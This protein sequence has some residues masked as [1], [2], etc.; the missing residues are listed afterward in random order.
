MEVAPGSLVIMTGAE[1]S[2]ACVTFEAYRKAPPL[3]T[4]GWEQVVEVGYRSPAGSLAFSDGDDID[5]R[6][7]GGFTLAGKGSYR[8]RIHVRGRDR[9]IEEIVPPDGTEE[10]LIMIYP[11]TGEK[12]V[13]HRG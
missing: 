1:E 13:V 5:G 6:T 7:F 4:R 9:A 8:V 12:A 3:R 2:H 10:Y 11:G